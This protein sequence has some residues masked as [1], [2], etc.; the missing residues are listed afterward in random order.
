VNRDDCP[1]PTSIDIPISFVTINA[2]LNA[3]PSSALSICNSDSVILVVSNGGLL[4]PTCS[5]QWI[6]DGIVLPS[7]NDTLTIFQGGSYTAIMSLDGCNDTS[8]T[9]SYFDVSLATDLSTTAT[10]I[11]GPTGPVTL[12]VDS[13]QSCNYSWWYGGTDLSTPSFT[14]LGSS[15]TDTSYTLIGSSARGWYQVRVSINGCIVSEDIYLDTIAPLNVTIV[16]VPVHFTICDGQ[17]VQLTASEPLGRPLSYQW[18]FNNNPISGAITQSNLASLGGSYD[19]RVIDTFGCI[20]FA[21]NLNVPEIDPPT[22]FSLNLNPVS[23][24]PLSY[25]NFHLDPY[26]LPSSLHTNASGFYSSVPQPAAVMLGAVPKDTFYTLAAGTGRHF[27]TYQYNQGACTFSVMDTIEVLS[28][29]SV[30]VVNLNNSAPPYESCLFDTV[31]FILSN[32]TFAPNQILFPTS[33]TTFDTVAVSNAGLTQ[34]A[35]VWSGNIN[36]IVPNGSVTGKVVFR[37]T[38]SG[39]QFQAPFFLVVQNPSVALSLNGVPQPLCSNAD[40]IALSGLLQLI[41]IQPM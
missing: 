32:F 36:V 17:P 1:S 34:F 16:P 41:A 31:R 29:M 15:F 38:V 37:N 5:Y 33:S 13:C 18:Y 26:L 10:R 8:L 11:C 30:D 3:T 22:N 2:A 28:S 14:S 40:T 39:D 24:I 20:D 6:R 4:C 35:G 9:R 27:V 23:V 25:G 21:G 19:V 12:S 7:T